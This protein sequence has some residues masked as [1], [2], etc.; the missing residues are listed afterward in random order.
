[1]ASP[2]TI[3]IASG[4][5]GRALPIIESSCGYSSRWPSLRQPKRKRTETELSPDYQ[6]VTRL[7]DNLASN[8][9]RNAFRQLTQPIPPR[10][11][12][13]VSG[14]GRHYA[15]QRSQPFHTLCERHRVT[16][17]KT[18]IHWAKIGSIPVNSM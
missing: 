6:V 11:D 1:M 5:L 15:L 3:V 18:G 8:R 16:V 2:R 7:P 17:L 10:D 4:W 14:T 9:R 13:I 12:L